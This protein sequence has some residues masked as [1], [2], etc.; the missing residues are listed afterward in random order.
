MVCPKSVRSCFNVLHVIVVNRLYAASLVR[1]SKR[2][3]VISDLQ[4]TE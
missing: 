2:D 1:L 3:N 4:V